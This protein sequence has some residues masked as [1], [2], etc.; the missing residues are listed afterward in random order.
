MAA[1]VMLLMPR[2]ISETRVVVMVAASMVSLIFAMITMRM[3]VCL[4]L[5]AS[6]CCS[7]LGRRL[8]PLQV[9]AGWLNLSRPF[10]FRLDRVRMGSGISWFTRTSAD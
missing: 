5:V 1:I 4:V 6:C 8:V 9:C 10:A 2:M 7:G 3:T